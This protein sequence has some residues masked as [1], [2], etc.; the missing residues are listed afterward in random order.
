MPRVHFFLSLLPAAL[1]SACGGDGGDINQPSNRPP[2]SISIVSRA[3]TQGT[4]AF[5]PNPLTVP[6]NG[7]VRW[8]NDDRDAAGGPYGGSNGTTH[9]VTADDVSFLSGNLNP[10]GTFEH[11]FAAAGTYPY[12]CSIHP[13]MRGTITV[14]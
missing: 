11:T 1:L 14:P 12:H 8:Y 6:V 2:N 3:E 10:G 7:V 13:T 5:S 4:G 9:T